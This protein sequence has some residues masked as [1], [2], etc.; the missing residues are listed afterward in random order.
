MFEIKACLSY[1]PLKLWKHV[2]KW[3][4]FAE[5]QTIQTQQRPQF[6]QEG[7]HEWQV[8]DIWNTWI[9]GMWHLTL[10]RVYYRYSRRIW[11]ASFI[12]DGQWEIYQA[13]MHS[14]HVWLIMPGRITVLFFHLTFEEKPAHAHAWMLGLLS[15]LILCIREKR[16]SFA[17]FLH[18]YTLIVF[19]YSR[20]TII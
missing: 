7:T 6:V 4:F 17:V 9:I 1:I 10:E 2:W 20:L 13:E 12:A 11:F 18:L 3:E 15:V 19:D 14:C 16:K 5:A 8:C